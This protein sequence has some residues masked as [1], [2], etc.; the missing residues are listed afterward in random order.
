VIPYSNFTYQVDYVTSLNSVPGGVVRPF[1]PLTKGKDGVVFTPANI[2]PYTGT[3]VVYRVTFSA[4]DSGRASASVVFDIAPNVVTLTL[5]TNPV[6]LTLNVD[7]QPKP[8]PVAVPSVVGFSR[9]LDAPLTQTLSNKLWSFFSW[10]D[11][12]PASHSIFTPTVNTTY[13][14]TYH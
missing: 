10:T 12:L 4:F 9:L 3:D 1:I 7:G 5:A 2:G 11:S 14:A 13:T 6:G 8:G